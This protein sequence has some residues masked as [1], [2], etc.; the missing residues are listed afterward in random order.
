MP[1]LVWFSKGFIIDRPLLAKGSRAILP[2]TLQVRQPMDSVCLPFS[3]TLLPLGL[4]SQFCSWRL[5]RV[6]P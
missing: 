3:D 4:S 1:Y 5:S 6:N 2:E